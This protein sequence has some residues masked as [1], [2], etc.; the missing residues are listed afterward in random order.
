MSI[1]DIT[2]YVRLTPGNTNPSVIG[3]MVRSEMNETLALAKAYTDSQ[4]LAYEEMET[5]VLMPETTLNF[6][7]MEELDGLPVAML[8]G[9][10]IILNDGDKVNVTWDGV[11]Y[12]CEF[13]NGRVF[14]DG[15][16][17]TGFGN[18]VITGL[19]DTGEPF[20]YVPGQEGMLSIFI[21]FS[22]GEH[23]ISIIKV[24]MVTK[25][26]DP[27]YLPKGGFGYE[28]TET[29]VLM[30]ESNLNFVINEYVNGMICALVNPFA[31]TY[32]DKM[33]V[34]WDGVQ[35][36]CKVQLIGETHAFGNFVLT[37]EDDAPDTGEPFLWLQFGGEALMVTAAEGEHTVSV[38]TE[39]VVPRSIDPKFITRDGVFQEVDLFERFGIDIS[40]QLDSKTYNKYYSPNAFCRYITKIYDAGKFPVLVFRYCMSVRDG[41]PAFTPPLGLCLG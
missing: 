20:A 3:S 19:E 40:G 31:L 26:I 12:E 35:Y 23:T 33:T 18:M 22:E 41:V 4:R 36:D 27:K 13:Y 21:A 32:G 8:E 24:D 34:I 38:T 14:P 11:K 16:S 2:D 25:T 17:I 7:P 30:P 28:E 29:K 5:K 1:K 37:G 9:P 10:S 39:V 15:S 6:V